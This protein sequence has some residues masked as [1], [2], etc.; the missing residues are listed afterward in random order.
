MN[1][2]NMYVFSIPFFPHLL[3]LTIFIPMGGSSCKAFGT[4]YNSSSST[5]LSGNL[6]H[7]YLVSPESVA[8]PRGEE[9]VLRLLLSRRGPAACGLPGSGPL[10][11]WTF[12]SGWVQVP[13]MVTSPSL[14]ESNE[15]ITENE[16]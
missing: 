3:T 16:Q 2:L 7:P 4:S 8:K 6:K 1:I 9:E 13:G 11:P 14:S 15:K 5:R 10:A 12:Q